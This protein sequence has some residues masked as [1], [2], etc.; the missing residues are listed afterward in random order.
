MMKPIVGL[1]ASHKRWIQV[2]EVALRDLHL[3]GHGK[4]AERAV[5]SL[6]EMLISEYHAAVQARETPFVKLRRGT[7]VLGPLECGA[8]YPLRLPSAIR[9]ALLSALGEPDRGDAWIAVTISAE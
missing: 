1:P 9:A 3:I 7:A 8:M 6:A 2:H 4:T 5:A